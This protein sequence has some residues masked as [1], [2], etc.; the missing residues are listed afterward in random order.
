MT[1]Y[2][3][4]TSSRRWVILAPVRNGKPQ[5]TGHAEKIKTEHGCAWS[6]KCPFCPG[7]ERLTTGEVDRMGGGICGS[8]WAS[9]VFANKYPITDIH[10]VIVHHPD[11]EREIEQM[12]TEEIS[13]LFSM[14]QH[15]LRALQK[16]GTPILFRNK[17]IRAGTS[18]SHP[19]SQIIVLPQ[20]INL[21][22]LTLE[23]IH[24][25]IV[26]SKYCVAYCP[27]F[28]QYP[29]EVWITHNS[30]IGQQIRSESVANINFNTFTAE[31][32]EDCAVV[33]Q[34][35]IKAL[36]EL[37][38][39]FPYNYYISPHP[40]FYLRIIPRI[41]TRGG[42]ELGTGLSTNIIDPAVAAE[43]IKKNL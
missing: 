9:R 36:K 17:G 42:F 11:H 39:E 4:D 19:H 32:L 23:P 12:T 35:I 5:I 34:K 29:Y 37:L 3:P 2:I 13:A 21:Q 24:N 27:D 43:T 20:Q 1:K 6:P 14:Y 30:A 25:V 26:K 18:I 7:N 8:D 28:S 10:E 16:D 31:E 40:P 22:T 15:R 33:L 38:D 41:I